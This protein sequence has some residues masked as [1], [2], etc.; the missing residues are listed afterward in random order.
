MAKLVNSVK[1][2]KEDEFS[3]VNQ[4]LF[5]KHLKEYLQTKYQPMIND[6]LKE[7]SSKGLSIAFINVEVADFQKHITKNDSFKMEPYIF[8]AIKLLKLINQELY[9]NKI[10]FRVMNN[11]NN[12]KCFVDK[13]KNIPAFT[14]KLEWTH[15]LK[16]KG[17]LS[18]ENLGTIIKNTKENE[19]DHIQIRLSDKLEYLKGKYDMH[20]TNIIKQSIKKE[21]KNV[22]IYFDEDEFKNSSRDNSYKFVAIKYMEGYALRIDEDNPFKYFVNDKQLSKLN[23]M[24]F[25][26]NI[27]WKHLE[28]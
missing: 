7:E 8:T 16:D 13:E 12:G 1:K 18:L 19:N 22:Q 27:S 24:Q 5:F 10:K 6:K 11:A 15:L 28:T 9:H 20:I 17:N 14:I 21:K 26:I 4:E 25:V 2:Q 3:N 23:K